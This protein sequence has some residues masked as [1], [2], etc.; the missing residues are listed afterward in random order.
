MDE[1][2][3]RQIGEAARQKVLSAHTAAHRAQELADFV[4]EVLRH[5]TATAG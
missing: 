2:Q 1:T 3:R 4:R 5:T